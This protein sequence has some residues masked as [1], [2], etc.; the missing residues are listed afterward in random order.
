MGEAYGTCEEK[1]NT[2][3]VLSV[4]PEG[5]GLFGR[6]RHQGKATNITDFKML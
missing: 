5:K 2:N 4:K 3:R 6:S 1:A